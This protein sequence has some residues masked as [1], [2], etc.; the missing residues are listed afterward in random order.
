LIL[1]W[2]QYGCATKMIVKTGQA[3]ARQLREFGA[4]N[5][6]GETRLQPNN[7]PGRAAFLD[8][9]IT[10]MVPGW[11]RSPGKML[12]CEISSGGMSS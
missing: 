2:C 11:G 4:V 10:M 12:L 8:R 1:K 3:H 9:A 6:L 7:C 5:A